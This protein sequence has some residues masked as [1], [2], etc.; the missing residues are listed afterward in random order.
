MK[1]YVRGIGT[2]GGFGC[3][4]EKLVSALFSGE[5][6]TGAVTLGIK[7]KTEVE[8]QAFVSDTSALSSFMAKKSLRRINNYS[9]LALL[10]ASLAIE[11]SG[12]KDFDRTRM[13]IIIASGYGAMNTTFSFLDSVIDE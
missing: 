3:G 9:K 10:G 5:S 4:V 12:I 7:G 2:V 6:S 13:G 1:T 11:D 8:T